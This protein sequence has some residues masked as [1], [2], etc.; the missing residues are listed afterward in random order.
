MAQ[1]HVPSQPDHTPYFPAWLANAT[2]RNPKPLVQL[3][4]DPD[5]PVYHWQNWDQP[6]YVPHPNDEGLVWDLIEWTDNP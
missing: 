4:P 5:G 1:L 2:P 3:G 6:V